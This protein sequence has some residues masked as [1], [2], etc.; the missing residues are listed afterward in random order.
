MAKK[1]SSTNNSK[2]VEDSAR[3]LRAVK[4]GFIGVLILMLLLMATIIHRFSSL[5]D[6]LAKVV[7]VNEQKLTLAFSM[8][9]AIRQRSVGLHKM[10]ASPDLFL[11]NEL[12]MKMQY[13]AKIYRES[14]EKLVDLKLN[15]QEYILEARLSKA[16]RDSQ[17]RVQE[18]MD[19]LMKNASVA[20]TEQMV[21]LGVQH[22]EQVLGILDELVQLQR[23]YS[24]ESVS[25]SLKS[26]RN[27]TRVV[28]IIS[29]IS[30]FIALGIARLVYRYI[31][32]HNKEMVLHNEELLDSYRRA[33]Q[34]DKAKSEF[35][36]NM[37]HEIRTPM[38]GVIGMIEMLNETQVSEEQAEFLKIADQSARSLLTVINDIL[39][40]SKIEAGKLNFETLSFD[41]AQVVDDVIA[42]MTES[43][44]RRN[45]ELCC[46]IDP[47]CSSLV[48]G[49]PL[50]LRQILNNLLGNAIKFT[51][52]GVI[53]VNVFRESDFYYRFE[54]RDNGIGMSDNAKLRIFEAF[55]QADGSTTRHYGGTGLGLSICSQLV[56]MFGGVIGVESQL[57]VGSCFWFTA[58]LM[59]S[60]VANTLSDPLRN[61]CNKR[62][63]LVSE[64]LDALNYLSSL[65]KSWGLPCA[66]THSAKNAQQEILDQFNNRQAY[67]L[68]L[69]DSSNTEMTCTEFKL[70]I[71]AIADYGRI[72][73][74]VFGYPH[75]GVLTWV[76]SQRIDAWLNYPVQQHAL[77]SCL[78]GLWSQPGTGVAPVENP[79]EMTQNFVGTVLLVEDNDVNVKVAGSMLAKLGVNYV[80]ALQGEMACNMREHHQYSLILM[81][82]QMPVLDGFQATQKIRQW[83]TKH[84]KER[85]PIIA[86]TA[87]AME[88]DRDRCIEAGMDDY[89]SKPLSLAKLQ[90]VFSKWLPC[91]KVE[92]AEKVIKSDISPVNAQIY[93]ELKSLMDKKELATLLGKYI[94]SGDAMLEKLG[95]SLV[96]ANFGNIYYAAHTLK[97]VSASVGAEIMSESCNAI[98][99]YVY[100]FT[101][102][103]QATKDD[104]KAL[105]LLLDK[106]KGDYER[107]RE[108]FKRV[109]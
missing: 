51:C 10:M 84:S 11:R 53:K 63:M 6:E 41:L 9:D 72:H 77:V 69:F 3:L 95:Q 79:P 100:E 106:L 65:L 55:S 12:Q 34:A 50:R 108:Y 70:F 26:N 61:F 71:S 75:S 21:N 33:E 8:R 103:K 76:K 28:I 18:A 29:L 14:R 7:Q 86:L 99:N 22:M 39:D 66:A 47:A 80:V 31:S 87:N 89:I 46:T 97:G 43:A 105:T 93:D 52:N 67:D 92:R 16:V 40:F 45:N 98:C 17:P 88:G 54:V 32:N 64:N 96:D 36:A 74:V 85:V 44:R 59:R 30:I 24:L 37:S 20:E 38:N 27:V 68:V 25:E 60:S 101:E 56:R 62:L 107:V 48:M 90:Q 109:A 57:G 91:E 58:R 94:T 102:N 5:S 82:C 4:L 19:L 49:D 2:P 35:L 1:L 73:L 81:D 104:L 42:S 15:G 83:E 13:F 78:I 23:K